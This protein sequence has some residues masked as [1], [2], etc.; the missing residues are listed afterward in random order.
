M[1]CRNNEAM[2][3]TD[4]ASNYYIEKGNFKSKIIIFEPL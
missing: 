2:Y 1:K 3:I 4:L